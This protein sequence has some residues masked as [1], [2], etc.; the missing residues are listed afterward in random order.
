MTCPEC[1]DLL[2]DGSGRPK[3]SDCGSDC[4][5][6]PGNDLLCDGPDRPRWSDFGCCP[7]CSSP[8]YLFVAGRLDFAYCPA[9][10]L[11]WLIGERNFDWL[12]SM[13]ANLKYIERHSEL[14]SHS[15]R[16]IPTPEQIEAEMRFY[17][18]ACEAAGKAGEAPVGE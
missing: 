16:V 9:C 14:L 17:A 5:C 15:R 1:N 4:G 10:R 2:C 13:R 3:Y 8:P 11:H 6:C 7:E 12:A 18:Q